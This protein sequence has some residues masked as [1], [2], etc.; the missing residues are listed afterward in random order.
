MFEWKNLFRGMLIGASDLIPGVSGGTIAIILGIYDRLIEA[1][2]GFFSKE[3]KKHIGFLLP[4]AIGIGTILLLL[5]RAIKW[6]LLQ[7][8]QPTLFFFSRFNFGCDPI[9]TKGSQLPYDL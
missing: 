4:L 2:S 9:F 5:S 6:L 3:W 1:I 7:Y 8:P